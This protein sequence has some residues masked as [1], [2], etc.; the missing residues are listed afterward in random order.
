MFVQA[1]K[2]AMMVTTYKSEAILKDWKIKQKSSIS[3]FSKVA[4][5]AA[6]LKT[7]T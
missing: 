3:E 4:W 2:Y 1:I 7:V 5:R 6:L